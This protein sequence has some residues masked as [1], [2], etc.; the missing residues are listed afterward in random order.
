MG[1]ESESSDERE[2][3]ISGESDEEDSSESVGDSDVFEV[4]LDSAQGGPNR[5]SDK[6]SLVKWHI[7]MLLLL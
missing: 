1:Y 7:T 6:I 5:H 2:M 4:Q 3:E